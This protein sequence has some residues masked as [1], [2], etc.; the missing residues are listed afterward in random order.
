MHNQYSDHLKPCPF[1]RGRAGVWDV[2]YGCFFVQCG[3][4]GCMTLKRNT[5]EAAISLWNKRPEEKQ[6]K[7]EG[8][9]RK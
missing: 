8:S 3:K 5:P 2:L 1:C 9:R 7:E 6:Q 4:C